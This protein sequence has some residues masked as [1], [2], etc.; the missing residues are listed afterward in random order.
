M[1]PLLQI[2]RLSASAFIRVHLRFLIFVSL[3]AVVP[4]W[5]KTPGTLGNPGN[6]GNQNHPKTPCAPRYIRVLSGTF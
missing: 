2:I 3:R 6:L 5:F 1:N 4:S